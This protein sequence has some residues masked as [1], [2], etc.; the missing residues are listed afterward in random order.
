MQESPSPPPLFIPERFE[1]FSV[2]FDG[3]WPEA[4]QEPNATIWI[5]STSGTAYF[6]KS[7]YPWHLKPGS[8]LTTSG[9]INKQ[10]KP[11]ASP[12]PWNGFYAV[13]KKSFPVERMRYV[14]SRYGNLIEIPLKSRT[15]QLAARLAK[16]KNPDPW[17]LALQSFE[18]FHEWWQEAEK[19]HDHK[20]KI[21][22]SL[23]SAT[24]GARE[25]PSLKVLADQL[26]YSPSYLS[27]MLKQKWKTTP[28]K[29][30][31]D[32]RMEFAAR[33]LLETDI[34]VAALANDLGYFSVSSFV[35]SFRISHGLPPEKFRQASRSQ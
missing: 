6:R 9:P 24:E 31:R 21:L 15:K 4:W 26:G 22:Q 23:K 29:M 1:K 19:Q 7:N 17:A 28:G 25:I 2:N 12:S 34:A 27:R 13:F 14:A 16:T 33:Q 20:L 30:L 32:A 3:C 10:L 18:W 35:R 11:T 5:L 8:A